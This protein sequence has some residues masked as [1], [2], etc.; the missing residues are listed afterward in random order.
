MG[1]ILCFIYDDMADFEMTLATTVASQWLEKELVTIAYEKEVITSKPGVQY[2]PHDTVKNALDFDDVEGIIIP[3]GWNDEQRTEL[4]DL[5]GKLHR[6]EKMLAAICAGPQYLAR[7]GVLNNNKYT[8]TL[9]EEYMKTQ[10]KEDFFPRDNFVK[11]NVVRDGNIITAVGR[12][13]VDF[14]VEIADYFGV[15]DNPEN[16]FTKESIANN[17]KGL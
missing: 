1:K 7:A 9:T 13:F 15:F 5:L 10:N 11:Q 12:A 14:A 17:Y 2:M 3:G 4:T 8:T 16:E 6:E